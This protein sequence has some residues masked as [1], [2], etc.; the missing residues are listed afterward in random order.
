MD[1]RITA[2]MSRALKLFGRVFARQSLLRL[3]ESIDELQRHFTDVAAASVADPEAL[4]AL[5][6]SENALEKTFQADEASFSRSDGGDWVR[7]DAPRTFPG[8]RR[9]APR[10]S[11]PAIRCERRPRSSRQL[12]TGSSPPCPKSYLSP[13]RCSSARATPSLRAASRPLPPAMASPIVDAVTTTTTTTTT[14]PDHRS[15]DDGC[16]D[17]GGGP[18]G[19]ARDL[20]LD[21]AQHPDSGGPAD[22]GDPQARAR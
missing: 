15:A 17:H 22:R 14:V 4:A 8:L 3:Q 5:A 11:R 1:K 10:G 20:G 18:F 21:D 16:L 13:S 9:C 6:D 7:R 2:S 12:V 19:L